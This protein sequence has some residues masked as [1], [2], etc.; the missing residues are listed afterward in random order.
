MKIK[1]YIKYSTD[2]TVKVNTVRVNMTFTLQ[3][4]EFVDFVLSLDK[5]RTGEIINN[6]PAGTGKT[7][8]A[9]YLNNEL[10][11]MIFIAPTHKACSLLSKD[12]TGVQTI[13]KFLNAKQNYDNDGNM[14][15]TFLPKKM[16]NMII[17]VD[18]CSMV[19][20][21]MYKEFQPLKNDNL[22]IYLGDELQLPPINKEE[23][24]D[25]DVGSKEERNSNLSLTFSVKQRFEFTKNMRSNKLVSTLMLELA[26]KSIYNG[27]MPAKIINRTLKDA[28][29]DFLDGKDVIILAYT[30]VAV[31]N[32]NKKI[33]SAL[34]KVD[35]DDLKPFYK[36]EHLIYSGYRQDYDEIRKE[37]IKY[38]SSDK[39]EINYLEIETLT[40]SFD[41]FQCDCKDKDY[42]KTLCEKHKFHKGSMNLDFYKITDQHNVKWYQPVNKNQFYIL[43][44]QYKKYCQ[45]Q[46]RGTLWK[47]YYDFMNLYN[48][49]LKYQYA[50]TIHK[51]Q[52]SQWKNVYVDRH[53]LIACTSKDKLLKLNAYY[54]AISR[55]VEEVYDLI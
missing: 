12:I 19:S 37:S 3:Q 22:I 15:F 6:S 40:L 25:E 51:S 30:N 33:R 26:R 45:M 23:F 54:T 53:N 32:Y 35:E 52:G 4:H 5:N 8:I 47:E 24:N 2:P 31:N 44:S 16:K 41:D 38:Y 20:D 1:L 27:K 42:K 49:D 29:Q 55:M 18:E 46:K 14:F 13:H 11:N 34:F 28:I 21:E 10:K 9:K 43:S 39:V 48:A 50:M 17:V 36:G 7:Y